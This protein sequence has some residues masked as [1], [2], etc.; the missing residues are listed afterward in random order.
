MSAD[1]LGEADHF[2]G[3]E[4]GFS[5]ISVGLVLPEFLCM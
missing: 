2:V 1:H 5:E 4:I 3:K